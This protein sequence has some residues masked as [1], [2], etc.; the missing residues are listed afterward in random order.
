[1]TTQLPTLP[2]FYDQLE[3]HDWFYIHTDDHR[4]WL[5]GKQSEFDIMSVVNRSEEH[6]ELFMAYRAFMFATEAQPANKP[7]R[8]DAPTNS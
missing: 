4:Y 1:M 7:A 6:A 5:N 3:E 8:P 2:E